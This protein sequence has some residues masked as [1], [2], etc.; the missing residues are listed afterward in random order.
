M[1]KDYIDVE[2]QIIEACVKLREA[3]KR[4]IVAMAQ[5]LRLLGHRLRARYNRQQ[6]RS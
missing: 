6:S 5:E 1:S 4:N 3:N 2:V